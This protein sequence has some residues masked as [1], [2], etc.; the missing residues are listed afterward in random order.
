MPALNSVEMARRQFREVA[1]IAG[2]IFQGFPGAH[3]SSKQLQASSGL[4]YDVFARFDPENLLIHQSQKEVM[5]KQL[6]QNRMS[7]ALRRLSR[8]RV[9]ITAPPRPTPLAFPILVDSL[10]ETLSTESVP[11]RIQK[12]ALRLEDEAGK[13][14][15]N[16]LDRPVP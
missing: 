9:L 16:P 12:L 6:E 1:R 15:H 8:S 4:F 7:R 2:L 3:K 11:D 5:E 10:R 14:V 13:A